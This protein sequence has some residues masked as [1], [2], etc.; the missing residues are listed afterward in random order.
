MRQTKSDGKGN[1]FQ[2]LTNTSLRSRVSEILRESI[3]SGKLQSG[4]PLKEIQLARQFQVSQSTVR[5]SLLQLEHDGLVVRVPNRETRVTK[6]STKEVCE[7]LVLRSLLEG[8]AGVEASRRMKEG[9]F[10]ILEQ[11]CEKLSRALEGNDYYKAA[12]ADLSFHRFLW[13]QSGN[14]TLYSVLDRLMTAVFAFVSIQQSD[15]Q[16]NLEDVVFPHMEIITAIRKGDLE[17]IRVTM[18]GHIETFYGELMQLERSNTPVHGI[19]GQT[20]LFVN[21]GGVADQ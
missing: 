12:Q 5:E 2:P 8:L 18:C 7:R 19:W 21:K 17:L 9:D 20:L 1:H 13:K 15:Q 6:L 4:D 14:Q 10:R 3:F 11:E 16:T